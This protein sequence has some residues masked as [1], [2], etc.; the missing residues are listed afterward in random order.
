MGKNIEKLNIS[1]N[2]VWKFDTIKSEGIQNLQNLPDMTV[3]NK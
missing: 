3:K 2:N 1:E